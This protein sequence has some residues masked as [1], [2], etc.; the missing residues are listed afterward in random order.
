MLKVRHASAKHENI[1]SRSRERSSSGWTTQSK[2]S[3]TCSGGE[4]LLQVRKEAMIQ[5]NRMRSTSSTKQPS[6]AAAVAFASI[7]AKGN[8]HR[9]Q[10]SS[11]VQLAGN[12][13]MKIPT[14]VVKGAGARQFASKWKK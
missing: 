4:K 5:S 1:L 8:A 7:T 2:S 13:R 11:I 6:F 14:Q 10:K 12:K 3:P 9:T